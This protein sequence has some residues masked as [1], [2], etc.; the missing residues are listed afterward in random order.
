MWGMKLQLS[1]MYQRQLL[2]WATTA[3]DNECCGLILGYGGLVTEVELTA[4]VSQDPQREFEIDPSALIAAEKRMRQGGV[5]ILGYFHS[6]P[7]GSPEPS[8]KDAQFAAVDGRRWLIIADGR[9]TSW[10]PVKNAADGAVTF[11]FEGFDEG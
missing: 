7:N 2:D 9:I 11:D 6:H 4:N 10:R 8:M 3:G 1:R 5:S